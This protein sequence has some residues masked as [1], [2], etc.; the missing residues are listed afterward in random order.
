MSNENTSVLGCLAKVCSNNHGGEC[1]TFGVNIGDVE[2]VCD[3]FVNNGVK[4]DINVTTTKIGTCNIKS[5][6]H[7]T[8]HKCTCRD[9]LMMFQVNRALCASYQPSWLNEYSL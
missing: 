9:I 7:N 6:Y 3:A 5:C 8:A 4:S 1:S 2:P